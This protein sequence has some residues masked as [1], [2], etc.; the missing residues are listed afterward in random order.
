MAPNERRRVF[1]AV[2]GT[3]QDGFELRANLDHAQTPA[4]LVGAAVVRGVK[5][6]VD[7][8]EHGCREHI[9]P[10]AAARCNPACV[11]TGERA[12]A[13]L[14]HLYLVDERA[15]L[16]ALLGEPRY[17]AIAPD[18][19]RVDLRA[20]ETSPAVRALLEAAA[21]AAGDGG[22]GDSGAPPVEVAVPTVVSCFRA[23]SFVPMASARAGE[24][25]SAADEYELT[26]FPHGLAGLTGAG[27]APDALSGGALDAALRAAEASLDSAAT[28][29]AR[30]VLATPAARTCAVARAAR[31]YDDDEVAALV[32]RAGLAGAVYG[33]LGALGARGASGADAHD[34]GVDGAGGGV[35]SL[36]EHGEQ[37]VLGLAGGTAGTSAA[38]HKLTAAPGAQPCPPGVSA[39]A[40]AAALKL[41]ASPK[42]AAANAAACATLAAVWP[43]L[44]RVRP[45]WEAI[46][47]AR[48]AAQAPKLILHAGPPLA[49]G[50]AAMCGPMRGAIIG[51]ILFEG[52]A[53]SAD[54]AEALARNGGVA[55]APCH[56]RRAVGPMSGVISPSMPVWVCVDGG[57]R[58]GG[59]ARAAELAAAPAAAPRG[60]VAFCNLNEG[61]GQVLRFGAHSEAVLER[62]RFMADSLAPALDGALLTMAAQPP[63]GA[64][65]GD[66]PVAGLALRPILGAALGMGD[67]G[68]NRCK[69]ITSLLVQ[70]FAPALVGAGNAPPT[71]ASASKSKGKP[72]RADPPTADAAAR[73]LAFMSGNAHF[74]LNCAM[75]ACKLALDA[76]AGVPHCTICTALCRNGINFGVRVAG[77]RALMHDAEP[78]S[79]AAD[80]PPAARPKRART[81]AAA[82]GDAPPQH[83]PLPGDAWFEAQSPNVP[84]AVWFAGYGAEDACRD[85]G[86]SAITETL[87]F[88]APAMAA[89][90]ALLAFVGGTAADALRYTAEAARIYAA[91][92][93]WDEQ[94]IPAL[95]WAGMPMVLDVARVVLYGQRPAIN[96]GI[97]HKQ[98]GIG[99]I[100]AGMSRAP[101]G[102][103]EAAVLH[104]AAELD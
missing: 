77:A 93:L 100:G 90:P 73:S 16:R 66:A 39:D 22:E 14:Y 53:A 23:P 13:N 28:A 36:D 34:D 88:G 78:T 67:E 60:A 4:V 83:V 46:H 32:A 82:T 17:L 7:V 35:M 45:A 81:A 50:F 99:Q 3:L 65:K 25:A 18:C 56:T 97:A 58:G 64:P 41:L 8:K 19:V 12:D 29:K 95:D 79:T 85:L 15:V 38:A 48:S 89:A 72:A 24:G 2:S 91:P 71:P 59:A 10:P 94:T 76:V 96:T 80:A 70:A 104:L 5:A 61:L 9:P 87:G 84:S 62:L 102:S 44:A 26:Q 42:V 103:F 20:A 31:Q 69:A 11:V 101:L 37:L 30:A 40:H 63:P 54:E 49:G 43:V 51:A 86:D 27:A 33:A 57:E 47:G 52:W 68:H 55:F 21:A 74:G 92:G 6:Y 98:A 1:L 75:A